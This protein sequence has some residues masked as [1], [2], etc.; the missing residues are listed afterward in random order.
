MDRKQTPQSPPE[1]KTTKKVSPPQDYFRSPPQDPNQ[2]KTKKTS[3]QHADGDKVCMGDPRLCQGHVDTTWLG[4]CTGE[5]LMAGGEKARVERRGDWKREKRIKV[6][7]WPTKK[8]LRE[9]R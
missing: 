6:R 8:A 9:E 2:R 4:F 3:H 5:R 1:A 7:T